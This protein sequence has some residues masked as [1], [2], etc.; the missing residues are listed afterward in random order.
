MKKFLY[1]FLVFMVTG[2]VSRNSV[3]RVA[4]FEA[5]C[6]EAVNGAWA[7]CKKPIKISQDCNVWIG[8]KR[9][10]QLIGYKIRVAASSDGKIILI[11]ADSDECG[12]IDANCQN[13][14]NNRNYLLLKNLF[15][16]NEIKIKKT[17]PMA[18]SDWIIGY[19]LFLDKEG[20]SLLK[21]L[22]VPSH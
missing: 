22:T 12:G 10:I 7:S 21:P 11:M 15:L 18:N 6:E 20:Y 14:A 16:R 2:C 13:N 19:Y 1:I 9:R 4:V 3:R 8:A 5:Q 17:I